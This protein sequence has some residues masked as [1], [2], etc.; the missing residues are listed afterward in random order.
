MFASWTHIKFYTFFLIKK[1]IEACGFEILKM[2]G[3]RPDLINCVNMK[4]YT[5]IIFSL[6]NFL[7]ILFG[8]LVKIF[9]SLFS[10]HI[11][12]V[13][14]ESNKSIDKNYLKKYEAYI[15]Y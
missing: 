7:L 1:E 9:P 13:A 2:S 4:L 14:K 8:L 11:I 6:F 15:S 10:Q 5:K 12:L 3:A